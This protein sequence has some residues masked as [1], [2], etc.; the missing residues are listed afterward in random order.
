MRRISQLPRL[1][2]VQ[3]DTCAPMVRAF[4]A[5]A[6]TIRP[7]YRVERPEGIAEAILRGD[8]SR[9]YPHIRRIVIESDGDFAA[10]SEAEIRHART[11]IEACEGISPCFSAS[12]A[13]A[14]L[15]I[16]VRSGV[17]DRDALIVVNLTGA[18]RSSQ[19]TAEPIHWAWR[20]ANGWMAEPPEAFMAHERN[21]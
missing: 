19:A 13:L 15:M 7:E 14:G 1:L 5:G 8:P 9:A 4:E 10:V 11:R 6:E 12:A 18:D 2:C 16:K 20:D 3:Q 21:V 17:V